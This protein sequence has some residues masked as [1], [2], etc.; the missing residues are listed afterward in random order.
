M[1]TIE[2]LTEK[3]GVP[4]FVAVHG[5]RS[6]LL[7]EVGKTG[8]AS[9]SPLRTVRAVLPHTARQSVSPRK[10]LNVRSMGL[11]QTLEPMTP[12]VSIWPAVGAT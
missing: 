11:T 8:L 1:Q 3:V 5:Y 4:K 9:L 12:E 6:R 7:I 2:V 10:G